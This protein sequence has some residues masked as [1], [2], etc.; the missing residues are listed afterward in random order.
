MFEDANRV[1]FKGERV[2]GLVKSLNK[3]LILSN[4]CSQIHILCKELGYKC[5]CE[6]CKKNK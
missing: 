5:N 6:K 3:K 4:I 2:E 1:Y